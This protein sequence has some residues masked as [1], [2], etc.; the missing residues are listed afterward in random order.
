MKL[1]STLVLAALVLAT[2]ACPPSQPLEQ[3]ARDT[4][5][6]AKGYLDSAK[7]QHP[8]C[9]ASGTTAVNPSTQCQVIN[10]GV[11]VKDALIDA[12]NVYCAS[13]SYTNGT[14]PCVPDKNAQPKLQ[15]ALNN[16]N[17]ILADVKAVAGQP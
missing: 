9:A 1:I 17:Q 15:A 6:T 7:S 13:D 4:A 2:T 12:I 14:G 5:A 3:T 16:L 11:G 8:E 10:K